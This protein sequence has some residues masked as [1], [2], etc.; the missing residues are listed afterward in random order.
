[1]DNTTISTNNVN[2]YNI[3]EESIV[4]N[5]NNIVNISDKTIQKNIPRSNTSADNDYMTN[6][7]IKVRI[8]KLKK[9]AF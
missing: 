3:D 5:Q 4:K 9:N 8:Y 2:G 1:M 6:G 7:T